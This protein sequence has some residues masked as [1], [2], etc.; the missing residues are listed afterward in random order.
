MYT[1]VEVGPSD[2][3]AFL[4]SREVR[5]K[6]YAGATYVGVDLN[7]Q[8]LER[9]LSRRRM[10]NNQ[11]YA[12]TGDIRN[13]PLCDSVADEIWLLNVLGGNL[14]GWMEPD[15]H[16][17]LTEIGRILKPSGTIFIG[18][19]LHRVREISWLMEEDYKPYGLVE[20]TYSGETLQTFVTQHGIRSGIVLK[21]TLPF[22]IALTRITP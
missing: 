22:F 1:I 8:Q 3:P 18:E 5:N 12:V 19:L 6:L 2:T 11:M 7:T 16:I 20:Q 4:Y 13:I 15:F 14:K 21:D 17:Y 10:H 9:E